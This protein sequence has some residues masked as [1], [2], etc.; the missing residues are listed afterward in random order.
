MEVQALKTFRCL[1]CGAI[2][3]LIKH[4]II[5]CKC[6]N[7]TFADGCN[8]YLQFGGRD[9]NKIDTVPAPE[10]GI[11]IKFFIGMPWSNQPNVNK[12]TN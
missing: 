2:V 6:P 7:H 3:L 10:H 12:F 9:M 4:E 5:R 1:E 11:S 8:E